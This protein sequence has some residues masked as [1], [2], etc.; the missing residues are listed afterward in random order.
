MD[1]G[2]DK[3]LDVE[4]GFAPLT[5]DC[6]TCKLMTSSGPNGVYTRRSVKA[7]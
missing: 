4:L 6:D 3:C 2:I 5:M 1:I 7:Y